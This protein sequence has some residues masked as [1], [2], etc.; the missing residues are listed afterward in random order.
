MERPEAL[1]IGSIVMSGIKAEHVLEIIEIV[2]K[3]ESSKSIPDAYK[4]PDSSTRVVNFILS[5]IKEYKF[6]NSLY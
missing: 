6:W 1:E 5:T 3:S 2:L 4:I